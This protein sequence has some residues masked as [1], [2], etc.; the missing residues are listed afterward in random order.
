VKTIRLLFYLA[1]LVCVLIVGFV[2]LEFFVGNE[3]TQKND[4]IDYVEGGN[5]FEN[6]EDFA[7]TPSDIP[8]IKN[9]F[10]NFSSSD[11]ESS[12]ITR[13]IIHDVTAPQRIK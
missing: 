7:D 5:N 3:Q 4:N 2:T 10:I 11:I 9:E 13:I 8:A 6:N 12:H 1:A